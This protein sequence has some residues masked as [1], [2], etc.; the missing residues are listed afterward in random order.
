MHAPWHPRIQFLFRKGC[1]LA[2]N[3]NTLR[4]VGPYLSK[5]LP[6]WNMKRDISLQRAFEPRVSPLVRQPGFGDR[7]SSDFRRFT[8]NLTRC[9]SLFFE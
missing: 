4:S 7:T 1:C 6:P 5:G 8:G 3:V 9:Q 2:S